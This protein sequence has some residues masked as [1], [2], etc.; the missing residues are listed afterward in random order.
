MFL[1]SLEIQGFKS[2]PDKT[3]LTFGNG[4]TAVVGPNGSG[5]S[6]ISDAIRWVLGEA[7]SKALRGSR[8]ED[9]IFGGTPSR[10][11]LGFA[12]VSLTID[13]SDRSLE[14]DSDDVKITRRYYRSGESEYMLNGKEVRLKDINEL[15]MDTGLGRDGYSIIGQG[16]ID[17]IVGAR[18]EDRREIFEE[19]A[20][21]SK[22]R[23]RKEDSER[24]LADAQENLVR[25][26][27]ILTELEAR[28]GPLREQSEKAKKYIDLAGEKKTLEV[29]LWLNDLD[30]HRAVLRE[31]DNRLE[32]SRA[33]YGSICEK[34]EKLQAE[35]ENAYLES[36]R[37]AARI[38]E[39][40]RQ[41]QEFEDTAA[42]KLAQADI[43]ENDILHN[44]ENIARIKEEIE[45]EQ[46]SGGESGEETKRITEAIEE[47]TKQSEKIA[48][49]LADCEN[50][51]TD[52][53]KQS[54]GISDEMEKAAA[55]ITALTMKQSEARIEKNGAIASLTHLKERESA[56]D[57]DIAARKQKAQQSEAALQDC[58]AKKI[59][60]CENIEILGNELKGYELKL[61]SRKERLSRID[62][63]I[64]S[65][66]LQYE[67]KM[68]RANMLEDM[69]RHLE[70]FSQSVKMVMREKSRGRLG[71]IHAPISK[72]IKVPQNYALA[73][74]TALGY[75]IQHIVVDTEEDAKQ[76]I[77]MLKQNKGGRATFLPI[78]SVSGRE[79][80]ER[81][82]ESEDGFIGTA[83][84]L[85]S[86]R[87]EYK[88]VVCSLLGRTV[89]AQSLD[90]AI[91]IAR[92]YG[93]R[94]RI[95]TLDGQ[96]VNSGGSMTGGSS[97]RNSGLLSRSAEIAELKKQAD[98][99][100]ERIDSFDGEK[101]TL[102]Q[103]ISALEAKLSGV[104]G[105]LATAQE[106]SIRLDGEM[107]RYEEQIA[108]A[109][110]DIKV[111]ENEKAQ[112][113]DRIAEYEKTAAADDEK[114]ALLT[115]QIEEAQHRV[116]ELGG[117]RSRLMQMREEREKMLSALQLEAVTCNKDIE[118]LKQKLE[119]IEKL[120]KSSEERILELKAQTADY[121][122]K[123]KQA[124]ADIE[125]LK[126]EAENLKRL[127]AEKVAECEKLS[128]ERDENERAN[129]KMRE[130]ERA[131]SEDKEKISKELARLEERKSTAQAEY[132][133]IIAK[134]LDE[135]ELTRSEAEKLVPKIED[136]ANAQ[137]KLSEVKNKIKALGA[138]NVGAIDEYKEV[139]ERYNF[140]KAQIEDIEKSKRE[141]GEL[142]DGLTKKMQDIFT[143]QFEI[144]N[145]N[146]QKTFTELFGGGSAHLEFTQPDDVLSSGIE[147]IVQPPG[148]IIKNLSILSGGERA[149]VAIAI[150][151]AILKVRPSPFCV[152]DEIEAALDDANVSRFAA[153]LRRLCD[154]TQFIVITH[155]RGTMDE[156]DVLYGVT[157][158][159]EGI[160]KMLT[161]NV[162]ELVEKLGIKAR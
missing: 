79:L 108:A 135:Y 130:D 126:A 32:Y 96:I 111:L 95:V 24:R 2:F 6:N 61:G 91:H 46:K 112:S 103:Q 58:K 87:P 118:A 52:I 31:H 159:D 5:K 147:I 55:A 119:D 57:N 10:K 14:Y 8:M 121:E 48:K 7:S 28:V 161:L 45:K 89:I 29:G 133:G 42:K 54:E 18:S 63:T 97:S 47:K 155:R 27:D 114:I 109:N 3:L 19:A 80:N 120:R 81:G 90:D 92:K 115:S 107:R 4:I 113:A 71:G 148:K 37:T 40:R 123:N 85:V 152:L 144:I 142:I 101:N 73:I 21:I 1:K 105:E 49:K 122:E 104:N 69:E 75:S 51:V 56:I 34:L 26:R 154:E 140:M 78:S 72:L 20:G 30:K 77:E 132:D 102:T 162:N 134:L 74:E 146:F 38:D 66:S 22:F 11:P 35:I 156:A 141:L 83:S 93:Y 59:K 60:C 160:S 67:S 139:S 86:F 68:Q 158:Q 43:Y 138:V 98:S 70:G 129:A 23:Y 17:E 131:L 9:V 33:Q 41:A 145:K 44:N 53:S 151:F 25:L 150:Y 116:E 16:R 64:R 65:F 110:A 76:A 99:I 88:G 82:L 94:F 149:L 13:N 128:A 137:K 12:E 39:S 15:L 84:E 106:D 124:R 127:N 143:N 117:N 50:G 36:Q 136:P 153:Y 157:M 125:A 100:K 62:E